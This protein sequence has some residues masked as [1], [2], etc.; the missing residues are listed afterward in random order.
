MFENIT[1]EAI[2]KRMLI[3]IPDDMDKREGSVIYD[4]LAPVALEAQNLYLALEGILNESFVDTASMPYLMRRAEERGIYRQSAT[5]A[6]L[7]VNTTPIDLDIPIGSRFTVGDLTYFVTE[8]IE[9]GVYSIQCETAG[10]VGNTYSGDIIPVDYI[11]NLQTIDIVGVTIPGED[12]ES[13]ASLRSR[14][15]KSISSQ[16]FGGNIAD[17]RQRVMEEVN[18]IGGVKVTPTHKGGGTVLL[19]IVDSSYNAPSSE[20]VEMVQTKVD[21]L[22]NQGN[23]YGIA[24]IGHTV[25][26][27]GAEAVPINIV[28]TIKYAD[29]WSWDASKSYIKEAIDAYLLELSK[30]WDKTNETSLIVRIS[31]IESAILQSQG[32]E[33]VMNTTI[34]GSDENLY[35][36]KY[37]LPIGGTVNGE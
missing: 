12:A 34:N 16:S 24:P 32:V 36:T 23:G 1:F 35:L 9:D 20:L 2:M 4:A 5:G 33:D 11:P 7:K 6:V 31:H 17:Y 8:K 26:V 27:E 22:E 25:T 30:E 3:M 10:V 37:Q 14:Y 18:G 21:P 28:T 29:D 13:E 15:Y 19:T